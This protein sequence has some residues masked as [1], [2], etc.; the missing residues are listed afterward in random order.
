MS[1]PRPAPQQEDQQVQDSGEAK[2][3]PLDSMTPDSR[4]NEKAKAVH[5]KECW[6]ESSHCGTG[7]CRGVG[8]IPGKA[9]CIKDLGLRQ[10]WQRSQLQLG[11]SVRPRNLHMPW[12]QPKNK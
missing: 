6:E 4:W 2:Q 3:R 5:G 8:S 9:Q 7:H 10:L 1:G 11:F 12:V